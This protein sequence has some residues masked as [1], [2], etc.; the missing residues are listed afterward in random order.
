MP[1]RH[2]PTAAVIL[3]AGRGT[4]FGGGKLLAALDDR[5]ILQHVLDLAASLRVSPVV[6]VLGTDAE[7]LR[8][9]CRWR[10]EV[11]VVNPRPDDGLSGSVRLGLA[12]LATTRA[13]RA[14]MLLADQPWLTSAQVEALLAAVPARPI[15][16]P[17]YRGTPGAPVLLERSAWPLA[18]QL[19]GDRGFSQLFATH[20]KLVSYVDVPGEN[21]DVDMPAD[22]SRG[23]A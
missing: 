16:V 23:E 22:L 4:R 2:R 1:Q 9:T 19:H 10:D 17:R 13:E 11:I 6:V 15:V 21:R 8:A 14:F 12:E 3:A 7:Q 18:A 5:P 20:P